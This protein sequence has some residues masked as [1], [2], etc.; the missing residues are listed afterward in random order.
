MKAALKKQDKLRKKLNV[1]SVGHRKRGR[2]CSSA[3]SFGRRLGKHL[4]L[5][6]PCWGQPQRLPESPPSSGQTVWRTLIYPEPLVS[7][8]W[9]RQVGIHEVSAPCSGG[10][11]LLGL[12]GLLLT[13]QA[14][15]TCVG[16]TP[17]IPHP[18]RV[19]GTG[20]R[21]DSGRKEGPASSQQGWGG[22]QELPQEAAVI[23]WELDSQ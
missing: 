2:C 12:A 16:I 4:G 5:P 1:W 11:V 22:F 17:W 14:G 9:S 6:N 19:L 20:Q 21:K 8:S 10:L 13:E 23:Q 15:A 7:L 3:G 18:P